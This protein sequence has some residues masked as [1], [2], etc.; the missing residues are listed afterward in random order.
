MPASLQL[1]RT[2]SGLLLN[3]G[4]RFHDLR[5]QATFLWAV[6]GLILEKSVHLGQWSRHHPG[7]TKQASRERRFSRW[8]HNPKIEALGLYAKL[9]RYALRDLV[10]SGI[11]LALD[12]SQLFPFCLDPGCTHL[13]WTEHS[14]CVECCQWKEQHIGTGKVLVCT[15]ASGEHLV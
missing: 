5:C 6:V 9:F 2:I 14:C 4:V 10:G 12:T 13:L 7:E 11:Y 1:Y 3:A 15:V 8:L